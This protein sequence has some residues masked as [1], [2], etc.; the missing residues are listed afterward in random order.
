MKI[1]K[2][3]SSLFFAFLA[4]QSSHSNAQEYAKN[5]I[6][7]A[8][9][10]YENVEILDFTGP[11]EVFAD[12][13]N[14]EGQLCRVYTVAITGNPIKAQG[15]LQVTPNY[16]LANAPA[17]D[18]IVIPGGHSD[19]VA[20]NPEVQKWLKKY[21]NG[22]TTFMS[23]CTGAFVLAGSGLLDGKSATSHYCCRKSLAEEYPKVKVVNEVRFVDNGNVIT[24]E[25]IS[26]GIDGSLYLLEKLFGHEV[27]K[28][29]A[30][31][32]MYDWRPESFNKVILN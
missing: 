12:A 32:M 24:T 9:M 27:A 10:V 31:Y 17:P 30:H 20:K 11:L 23:V 25:G 1:S 19:P 18:V 21:S 2:I 22:K 8:V 13:S 28:D 3:T 14:D 15:I 6:N 5:A 26:A 4:F 16:S 29:V 7:V